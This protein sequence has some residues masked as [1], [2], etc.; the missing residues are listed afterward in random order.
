MAFAK[1]QIQSLVERGVE[2]RSFFLASRSSPWILVKEWLRLRSEIRAFQPTLIHVQYGTMTGF[3][4]ACATRRPLVVTFRGSDLNPSRDK[5]RLRCLTGRLQSQLVA[6]RAKRIICVSEQLAR[7][8]WWRKSRVSVIASGVDTRKFCPR[9]QETV[10]RQLGWD[11]EER[12]VLF[13]GANPKVKR[14]DL[15]EAAVQAARAICGDIRFAC[16]DGSQSFELISLMMN[17]AD[18]LLM[19]SD[20]EGSPNIV[21]E[22]VASGLPVVSRDVGDV[23]QRLQGVSPS[24]IVGA[25]PSEIGAAIAEILADR[26]RANVPPAIERISLDGIAGQVQSV[27]QAALGD[28][29]R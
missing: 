2:G 13:N 20:F 5:S 23:R 9:P 24:R 18:C 27:Y 17:A 1:Q 26:Q 22:A 11:P 8:L 19:T 28:R 4:C 16:L 25:D 10:R 6:L 21:K 7:R 29:C 15:A 14:L 3:F 12:V